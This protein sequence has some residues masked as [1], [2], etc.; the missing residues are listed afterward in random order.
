[1][2]K[3]LELFGNRGGKRKGAG[4]KKVHKDLLP[5]TKRPP[6]SIHH[7]LHVV[8]KLR[9]GVKTLRKKDC[10]TIFRDSV[11]KAKDFGI[12]IVHFSVQSNHIHLI[13]ES[14]SRLA[15]SRGM[16]SLTIRLAKG[17]NNVHGTFGK[18]FK[19]RY[20]L[21]VLKTPTEVKEALVYVFKNTAK[22]IKSKNL[23]DPFSSI[24]IF[25][26]K[27]TLLKGEL[28]DDSIISQEKLEWFRGELIRILGPPI[29]FL[30]SEG[31]KRSK[32]LRA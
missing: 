28:I 15:L 12:N 17:I 8:I 18:L 24:L 30:L 10:Y 7:P 6:I 16:K 5:H 22:A 14:K 32:R 2:K 26:D 3:Q 13:I 19:D 4:R 9:Q 25:K 1:M 29:S 20:Y 23:F 27:N 11:K 31:W 21:H